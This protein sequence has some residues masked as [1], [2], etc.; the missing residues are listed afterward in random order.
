LVISAIGWRKNTGK[1]VFETGAERSVKP[2]GHA[3]GHQ[4]ASHTVARPIV[5]VDALCSEGQGKAHAALLPQ[6]CDWPILAI[7]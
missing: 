1:T 5:A 3:S 4:S 6:G 2:L 7:K